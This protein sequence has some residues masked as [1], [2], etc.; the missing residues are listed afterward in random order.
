MVEQRLGFRFKN[1]DT[2]ED[3]HSTEFPGI[4]AKTESIPLMPTK[5]QNKQSII[6]R[7]GQV[8]FSDGYNNKTPITNVKILEKNDF[9][10]AR[11]FRELAVWLSGAGELIFDIEPEIIWYAQL[12]NEIPA[13][14]SAL[15]IDEFILAWDCKP[16]NESN[17]TDTVLL[18]SEILLGSDIP[19]GGYASEIS[20]TGTETF[21][22]DGTYYAEP[23]IRFEGTATLLTVT[24]TTT[25]KTFSIS[26][27]TSDTT[28]DIKELEVFDLS[29][30]KALDFT[31]DI[32]D[33]YIERGD[34]V[35]EVSGT[36]V[37]GTTYIEYR[38]S[39]L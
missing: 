25:G 38:Q 22:N 13:D 8:T 32:D 6:G 21:V 4:L 20:G 27:I 3:R 31:G 16:I 36:D 9:I 28:V 15:E 35:I 7:N 10:L 37:V 33:F 14:K 11:T 39:Y 23:V 18:G 19:L 12:L 29:G 30:N 1:Y 26:D 17:Y 2:G 34:N 24:N 5:R